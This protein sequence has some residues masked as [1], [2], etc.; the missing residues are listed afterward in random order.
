[1]KYKI[2][3]TLVFLGS[4]LQTTLYSLVLFFAYSYYTAPNAG[5]II[6][7]IFP[8]LTII[9]FILALVQNTLT[10]SSIKP[11]I[12]I[13]SAVFYL[14]VAGFFFYPV[15]SCIPIF[16]MLTFVMYIPLMLRKRFGSRYGNK[17]VA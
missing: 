17:A 4:L 5:L 13:L 16:L 6:V 12:W 11:R 1:M 14:I 8:F 9:F 2:Y 15:W 3:I 10:L 7:T